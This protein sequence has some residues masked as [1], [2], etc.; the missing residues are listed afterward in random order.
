MCENIFQYRR[1]KANFAMLSA[2]DLEV[3]HRGLFCQCNSQC[4][5]AID[6]PKSSVPDPEPDPDPVSH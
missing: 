4:F 3:L 1:L 2:F 6:A 5:I